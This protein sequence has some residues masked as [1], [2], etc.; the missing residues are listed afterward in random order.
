MAEET[1]GM[2]FQPTN[3]GQVQGYQSVNAYTNPSV[4][5]SDFTVIQQNLSQAGQGIIQ[6]AMAIQA[7]RIKI[8]KDLRDSYNEYTQK[9]L[10]EANKMMGQKVQ[11]TM[12]LNIESFDDFINMTEQQKQR[13]LLSVDEFNNANKIVEK[14]MAEIGSYQID[15]RDTSKPSVRLI[16]EMQKGNAD[17]FEMIPFKD[18]RIGADYKLK[19][20]DENGNFTGE[21]VTITQDQLITQL[22]T[23]K[24]IEPVISGLNKQMSDVA[25]KIQPIINA[26]ATR[27]V[28]D[29]DV[30]V[31]REVKN[32]FE[33]TIMPD[34][35]EAYYANVISPGEDY[36]PEIDPRTG[37]KFKNQKEKEEYHNF[38]DSKFINYLRNQLKSQTYQPAIVVP[39]Q[40]TSGGGSGSGSKTQYKRL[41][42]QLQID[43]VESMNI[44]KAGIN[45]PFINER[46]YKIPENFNFEFQEENINGKNIRLV[47][48]EAT[49]SLIGKSILDGDKR[50][51]IK[52]AYINEQGILKISSDVYDNQT[53]SLVLKDQ[54]SNFDKNNINNI[55]EYTAGVN[56]VTT[57]TNLTAGE[58]LKKYSR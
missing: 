36:H 10:I 31:N 11:E 50:L 28:A 54:A 6:S 1:Q 3:F 57:G 2:N 16:S 41:D 9:R 34:T 8:E 37:E 52:D 40:E 7:E 43:L 38:Q 53:G 4:F 55:L 18:G 27:G 13:T 47:R 12:N 58:L 51:S 5:A 42:Q 19:L 35:K 14:S 24:N 23:V 32:L 48:N 17:A 56:N 20:R 25:T 26:S 44:V 49:Q 21:T 46:L 22:G 30:Q 33:T 39:T 29:S 45:T 15:V